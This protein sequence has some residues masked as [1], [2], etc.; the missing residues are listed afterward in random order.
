MYD[1][2]P[3]EAMWLILVKYGIPEKL[4]NIIKSITC[5]LM[6]YNIAYIKVLEYLAPTL[7]ILFF[8]MVIQC[9]HD[10]CQHLGIKLLYR[11]G[12]SV[13]VREL[14][15]SCNLGRQNCVL[16]IMLLS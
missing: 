10:R 15:H 7:F 2:V 16:Q 12:G 3:K 9:W 11:Y 13:L 4:V 1:S 5:K 6:C 14:E 8:N